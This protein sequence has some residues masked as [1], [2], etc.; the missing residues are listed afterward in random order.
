MKSEA[1]KRPS[2][3]ISG[4]PIA[5]AVYLIPLLRQMAREKKIA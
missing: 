1:S 4:A 2:E 3:R 5:V